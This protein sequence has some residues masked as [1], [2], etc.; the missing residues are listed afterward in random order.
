MIDHYALRTTLG[1]QPARPSV[2][3]QI[4][5][6]IMRRG[7]YR[8]T[9][10]HSTVLGRTDTAGAVHSLPR[11]GTEGHVNRATGTTDAQARVDANSSPGDWGANRCEEQSAGG[12][13]DAATNQ[14]K[15]GPYGP[16]DTK[17]ATGLEPATFSLEG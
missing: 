8:T 1:T 10:T 15:N 2:A 13:D 11:I 3:P 12:T 14:M 6:R 17:R 7:D 5:Q 9:L 4:A 16:S